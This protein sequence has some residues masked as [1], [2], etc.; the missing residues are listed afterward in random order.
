MVCDEKFGSGKAAMKLAS[1][2][3]RRPLS[4]VSESQL[5]INT[6]HSFGDRFVALV[7][8]AGQSNHREFHKRFDHRFPPPIS[9]LEPHQYWNELGVTRF[10]CDKL[11]WSPARVSMRS[12]TEGVSSWK[13]FGVQ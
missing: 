3:R 5:E 4:F 11:A 6:V 13:L 10:F 1:A 9:Y 12:T 2:W 7:A 8:C